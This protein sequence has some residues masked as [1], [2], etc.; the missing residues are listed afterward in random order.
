MMQH[1]G[2]DKT[3]SKRPTLINVDD[4]EHRQT[5]KWEH[6]RHEALKRLQECKILGTTTTDKVQQQQDTMYK[7]KRANTTARPQK[8]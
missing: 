2:D 8:K 5:A 7:R 4:T 1:N 6:D 3:P